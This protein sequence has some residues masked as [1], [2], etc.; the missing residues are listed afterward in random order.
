MPP[1]AAFKLQEIKRPEH[2]RKPSEVQNFE[3]CLI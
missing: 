2:F 3:G 1:N